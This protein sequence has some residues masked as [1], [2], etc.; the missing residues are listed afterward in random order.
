MSKYNQDLEIIDKLHDF[1]SGNQ[2]SFLYI[3]NRFSSLV[4]KI[5]SSYYLNGADKQDLI[6]EGFIGLYKAARDYNVSHKLSFNSF[7]AICIRRQVI[8]A[9]KT[10]NRLKHQPLNI[11][12]SF[13]QTISNDIDS[14]DFETI[15]SSATPNPEEQYITNETLVEVNTKIN[16]HFSSLEF[17]VFILYLKG[18]SYKEI[19]QEL[20]FTYKS[21]DNAVWRVKNKLKR[22][23]QN[24]SS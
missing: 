19:C 14:E 16:D 9:I 2:D 21:V 24:I 15:L 20:G 23:E 4:K 8:N 12:I 11:R 18:L 13:S 1:Q 3:Y 5:T 22:I 7:A 10:S 17:R 6:Q